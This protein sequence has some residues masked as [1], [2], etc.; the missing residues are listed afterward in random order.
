VQLRAPQ[1][2]VGV[3]VADAAHQ[4][5]V[6]QRP[7]EAGT[8][9]PQARHERGAVERGV[10]RVP[11]DVGHRGRHD[12]AAGLDQRVD[13][14][15]AERALVHEPQLATAVRERQPDPQVLLVRRVGALDEQLP[16]HA[17][18][19]GDGLAGVQRQPQVLAAALRRGDR[20]AHDPPGEVRG[21]GLVPPDRPGVVHLDRVD[22][23]AGHPPR[24]AVADDLDL[25]ELG[26]AATGCPRRAARPPH[27]RRRARRR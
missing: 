4:R 9:G 1:G 26:H 20:P 24:E 27:P 25:G 18:V 14:E 15:A 17:E 23:P 5:L 13:R 7:L 21:T 8:P 12:R 11:G 16:A 6:E 2:L 19:G 10:E 3:D 22:G